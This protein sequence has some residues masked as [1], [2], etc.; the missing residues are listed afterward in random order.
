MAV[1]SCKDC[2]ASLQ[3]RVAVITRN[4]INGGTYSYT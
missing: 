3:M 2:V 1:G 4:K